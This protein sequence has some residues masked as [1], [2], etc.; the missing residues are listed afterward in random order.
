MSYYITDY[1]YVSQ[2]L[3]KQKCDFLGLRTYYVFPFYPT[4][5]VTPQL[6]N[7]VI[8]HLREN[9]ETVKDFCLQN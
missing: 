8:A 5:Q 2:R 9:L 4:V 1:C 7:Y 3:V 6:R